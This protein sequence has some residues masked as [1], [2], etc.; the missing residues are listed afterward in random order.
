MAGLDR[1]M[2]LPETDRSIATLAEEDPAALI[3]HG[4]SL[5]DANGT[6]VRELSAFAE[7]LAT[8]HGVNFYRLMA[9]H[10]EVVE[11]NFSE[12]LAVPES[13]IERHDDLIA[14]SQ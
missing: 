5:A 13:V 1:V 14:E 7:T 4:A 10:P 12:Q 2:D 11:A 6:G 8:E 9:E 3:E